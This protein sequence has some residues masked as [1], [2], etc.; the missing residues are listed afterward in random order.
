MGQIEKT[1]SFSERGS[2]TENNGTITNVQLHMVIEKFNC[3]ENFKNLQI[4]ETV[5]LLNGHVEL[6]IG[7]GTVIFSER[8]SF[9]KANSF[10]NLT[11]FRIIDFLTSADLT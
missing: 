2:L 7:N 3:F 5:E 9:R 11:Q 10:F 4:F 1:V 8:S 6:D